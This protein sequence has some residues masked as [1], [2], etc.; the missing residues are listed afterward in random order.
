MYDSLYSRRFLISEYL[1]MRLG[2]IQFRNDG[3]AMLIF[4][5]LLY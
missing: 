2:T 5:H 1:L 4:H 3:L